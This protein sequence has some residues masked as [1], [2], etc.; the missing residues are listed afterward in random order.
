LFLNTCAGISIISQAAPMAQEITGVSATVAAGLVG[1]ISIANGSGR[2]LWAWFSDL[3]GRRWVF[4]AMFV[5]QGIVFALMPRVHN[6][7]AFTTLSFIILLC[8][9]GGFGTMPAFAADYF[10]PENV[11]SIYGLMLTAWG[12]AGLFGPMMIARVRQTTGQYSGALYIIAVVM[13]CSA[14]IPL[15]VR[16]PAVRREPIP[17]RRVA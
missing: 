11:G 9:G 1:I 7:P 2:F 6:F 8:Y 3:A 15:M 12:F 14:V 10:G 5:I 13:L 4:L 17:F 16:P